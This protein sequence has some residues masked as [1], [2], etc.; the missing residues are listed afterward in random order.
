MFIFLT[1]IATP[2]PLRWRF[3]PVALT[4]GWLLAIGAL[5]LRPD[6]DAVEAVGRSPWWC[7]VCGE[8]G[9]A[10]L[11]LN[12]VLFAPLGWGLVRLGRSVPAT[13][14]LAA[15]VSVAIE[16][17]QGLALPGRDA[18]LGDVVANTLGAGI[19]WW[20]ASALQAGR[21]G[22]WLAPATLAA[23]AGTLVASTLLS[24]PAP[25]ER[26]AVVRLTPSTDDR[27]AYPGTVLRLAVGTTEHVGPSG[28]PVALPEPPTAAAAFTWAAPGNQAASIARIEDHRG[29][30]IVHLTRTAAGVELGVRTV[31]GRLRF[32]TP[33]WLMPV[34]DAASGDTVEVRLHLARGIARLAG[35][36]ASGESTVVIR[37]GP[38]HGWLLLNPYAPTAATTASWRWWTLAWLFAWGAVLGIGAARRRRPLWWGAAAV[39]G[40][41]A[42]AF[43][44]GAPATA[45]EGLA[46]MVGWLLA[47]RTARLRRSPAG[48]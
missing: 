39:I 45:D 26:N 28:H 32:R 42:C 19:G 24:A 31:G 7:L 9:T 1:K 18:A 33:T 46:L 10:D 6:P 13:I 35:R 2:I 47:V 30:P 23:F 44:A 41:L 12:L 43:A 21:A 20:L 40:L 22:R 36:T 4:I 37:Y 11:L 16:V 25:A 3:A 5:T 14:L 27:P 29:W 15:S 8:A 17:T 34:R 38:Q 48:A